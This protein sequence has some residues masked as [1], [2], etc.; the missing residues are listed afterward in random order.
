MKLTKFSRFLGFALALVC[1][2]GTI[3][4]P[5]SQ[6][7]NIAL[8]EYNE[9]IVRVGMCVDAPLLDNRVFSSKV[10]S[11]K[12]FEIGYSES[13]G[14]SKLFTISETK[15]VVLPQVN[16]NF[17]S[18]NMNCTSGSGNVGAYSAL[19]SSHGSYSE[20]F[21]A[22]DAFG[23]FV[24][25]V[26]G[27]FEARAFSAS[28]SGAVSSVCEGR[29]VK[30]PV[31]GGFLVLNSEGKIILSFEDV[32]KPFALRGV[33][34]SLV[35][36]PTIHRSGAVN[37]YSYQ[38]YVEY[39]Q[40]GGKLWV[41]NCIGL[42][43]Y[44][45]CVMANEIGTNVSKET[46][47]AFA[48]LA[49]TVPLNSKHKSLGFDVCCNSACCQV[50]YGTHRMS[51]ENNAIVDSTRGLF[52]AYNGKPIT[53]LYHNSNGGASCSSVAAWGGNEVPYLTSVFLDE[54]GETDTWK[55]EYTKDEFYKYLRSRRTFSSLK[56]KNISMQI[57]ET[58]PYGSNYITVLSVTDGCG[59]TITVEN[60]EDIRSACGF[61]S[62]NFDIEY[63]AQAVIVD[64]NGNKKTVNVKGIVTDDGIKP[65]TGFD[66]A[67][68]VQ[69]VGTVQA[70]KVVINGEGTG[71]GV[72]FSAIGSEKLAADGYSYEYILGFFFPGTNLKY[73]K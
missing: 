35:S 64:E 63:Q 10:E 27:G 23:G 59:N 45:K 21:S 60:S 67:Y 33:G 66:E 73:A 11:A 62:A 54:G 39:T 71:H 6:E 50:Y 20:A 36:F 13:A 68:H 55:K 51:E 42:E 7:E 41:V 24:A 32:S 69:G 25:V 72:G 12:G 29:N 28:S 58:D 49:R 43:D 48:V 3:A 47:R 14:F 44:T 22:A 38:G 18:S 4:V 52:C 19:I 40:K 34:G 1:F 16:A 65:F 8:A 53:V 2:A 57:V 61:S 46:R 31:S 17:H 5:K 37:T 70:D 30:S 15:I 9:P 26:N 56:D